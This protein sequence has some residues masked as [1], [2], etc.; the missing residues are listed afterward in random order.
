MKGHCY[1]EYAFCMWAAEILERPVKWVG[2]REES[3]LTD[4]QARDNISEAEL[5][6][7]DAG[8]FLALRVKTTANIG[9]ILPQTAPPGQTLAI[10]AL[11]P[12]PIRRKQCGLKYSAS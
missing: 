9:A 3:L 6:L 4:D 11:W 1:A 12:V 2:N 8:K 10:L 7:D 5:A